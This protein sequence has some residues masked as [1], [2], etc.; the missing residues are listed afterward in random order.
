MLGFGLVIGL[1]FPFAVD[2]FVAWIPGKRLSFALM[3]IGAGLM[4]GGVGFLI[5]QRIVIRRFSLMAAELKKNV[6][7]S[8]NLSTTIPVESSDAIGE[9]AA[10]LNSFTL[11]LR[12]ISSSTRHAASSLD[13][14]FSS[15]SAKITPLLHSVGEYRT[16]ADEIEKQLGALDTGMEEVVE[17]IRRIAGHMEENSAAILEQEANIQEVDGQADEVLDGISNTVASV[18]QL[19]ASIRQV[20]EGSASM[21]AAATATLDL[22]G[23]MTQGVE[24]I[25]TMVAEADR[26][27]GNVVDEAKIGVALVSRVIEAMGCIDERERESSATL[28]E[29]RRASESVGE[30]VI[31]M[32]AI[33]GQTGL[34]ALN[35]S[36]I[37]AQAGEEGRSFAVVANSIRGLSDKAS[38]STREAGE[39]LAG[40]REGI[41]RA[42]ATAEQSREETAR[43][44]NLS[45]E[46]G[47]ALEKILAM[48]RQERE[49]V[50]SIGNVA[51][52]QAEHNRLITEAMER[53]SSMTA[54]VAGATG[55][56]SRGIG[57]ITG[58]VDRL[59]EIAQ[60]VKRA[61][62]EQRKT[63]R[64]LADATEKT[65]YL[66][67][68]AV[69]A[70]SD[71]AVR[72]RRSL[73]LL[74][75]IRNTAEGG[76]GMG[77]A[78]GKDV[79]AA[80]ATLEELKESV[81]KFK[82]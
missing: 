80:G 46:A 4:V 32:R 50:T 40:I 39:I 15:L 69:E 43:G 64:Q 81:R 60:L 62:A 66:V 82:L 17:R 76:K 77:E 59:R 26:F 63:S 52:Q 73:G 6:L 70:Q 79:A 22:V 68:G 7:S 53:V 14:S 24:Q 10:T 23:Q 44:V 72:T 42:Y 56:E 48:I 30:I 20:A 12:K 37:A 38:S 67:K 27:S 16:R 1:V 3:C 31:A 49:R 71:H 29:L 19:S 35:A 58:T 75:G 74:E 41:D 55:E 13:G 21:S 25:R 57:Q 2:P 33:A 47:D 9:V 36:I 5:V 51:S 28:E 54:Q 18:A 65:A 61:L 78:I 11:N 34:L 45:A 8:G